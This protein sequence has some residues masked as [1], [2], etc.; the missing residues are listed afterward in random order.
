MEM[1]MEME[2]REWPTQILVIPYDPLTLRN[3]QTTYPAL[4][5]LLLLAVVFG[6]ALLCY[7]FSKLALVREWCFAAS[8]T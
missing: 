5:Q 4:H 1:E 6:R 2:I 3:E 8:L 7:T